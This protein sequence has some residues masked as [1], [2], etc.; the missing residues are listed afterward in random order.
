MKTS[1][2]RNSILMLVILL[3]T[4]TIILTNYIFTKDIINSMNETLIEIEY[5]KIWWK[6]NYLIMQEI[7]KR[8][9]L[10][11]IDIIKKEQPEL[12]KEILN[13]QSIDNNKT[14]YKILNENIIKD[15]KK[16][17]SIVWNS[18][19]LISIIEF[20]D[21]ECPF[22]IIQHIEWN[23]TKILEKFENN[24]N[25][26]FKNFP[27]PTHK[28]AKIE[29][30]AVK[31]IEN[32]EWWDKYHKYIDSIFNNTKWGWEWLKQEKLINLTDDFIIN[33][34]NFEQCL[35]NWDTKEQV[36]KEFKQ[37]IMLWINSVPSTVVINNKTWKYTIISE[38][39]KYEE[40]ENIVNNIIN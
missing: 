37:W 16:S 39:I 12:I 18:W 13:K 25:Y 23:N 20:S 10:W 9:I 28:N 34:E 2:K 5:K 29:A 3:C 14:E 17:T 36:E 21:L 19:A 6:E 15:L 40:L 32:L 33:K 27:L 24:V 30:Q 11:Y 1:A 26:I 7:Q 4:I 22:C 8:E 38:A 35:K 31:C